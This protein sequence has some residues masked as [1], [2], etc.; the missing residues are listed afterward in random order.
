MARDSITWT[1]SGRQ[2]CPC[3][4]TKLYGD[5]HKGTDAWPISTAKPPITPSPTTGYAHPKCY[6][7]STYDCCDKI[8]KEHWLSQAVLRQI[9]ELTV[10][11]LPQS[12]KSPVT[13]GLNSLAAKVLCSRHNAA[14]SELDT[15]AGYAFA[16]LNAALGHLLN[17]QQNR[18]LERNFLVDGFAI[19]LWSLKALLGAH[20]GGI[21][22]ASGVPTRDALTFDMPAAVSTLTTGQF[23]SGTGLYY[24]SQ[25]NRS[26]AAAIATLSDQA[27]LVGGHFV[28]AQFS[29]HLAIDCPPEDPYT[30]KRLRPRAIRVHHEEFVSN[31]VFAWDEMRVGDHL[32]ETNLP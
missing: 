21:L 5:C 1:V 3:G 27:K 29:Y 2:P 8:S 11:G 14:L 6:M 25:W 15:S 23:R 20:H 12:R 7:A 4:S 26:A 31:I 22:A 9:G 18:R 16:N 32:I 19:E 10:I 30:T 24:I 13:V 17:P 28:L